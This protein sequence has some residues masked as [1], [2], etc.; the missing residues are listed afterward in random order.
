MDIPIQKTQKP[1]SNETQAAEG[2]PSEYT[3]K[4]L[5]AAGIPF[6][7]NKSNTPKAH[8][9]ALVTL[10]PYMRRHLLEGV[11]DNVVASQRQYA[12]KTRLRALDRANMDQLIGGAY[13]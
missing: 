13:L 11:P 2:T 1:F 10:M 4:V 8:G 7:T 5:T 12:N 3:A 6:Q 9:P